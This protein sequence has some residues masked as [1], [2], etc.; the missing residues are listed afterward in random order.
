MVKKRRLNRGLEA[1]LQGVSSLDTDLTPQ[2]RDSDIQEMPIDWL[3]RGT[4]QPRRDMDQDALANLTN[5]I[6]NYGMMQPIVARPIGVDRYEIIAGERRWRAAQ[7]AEL[8]SVPVLIRD[9]PDEDAIAMALIENIQREN[10]NPVDEAIAL[11]RLQTEFAM[12]QQQMADMLGKSRSAIA[13]ILRLMNLKP[14][15]QQMLKRG[16]LEMGHARCLLSLPHE[17]Q[18]ELA[19]EVFEKCLSVRQTEA[20]VRK[21]LTQSK[22]KTTVKSKDPDLHSLEKNL[23]ALFESPVLIQQTTK[24]KGRLV[25]QYGSLAQLDGIIERLDAKS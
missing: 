17:Q 7:Q 19:R 9:V 5:S 4:Y 1:L 22:Y 15:V 6:S 12:T 11:Q 2:Q 8:T 24:D 20:L 25:I 16:D 21:Q 13:N 3:Q 14:E 23:S 18:N 10:L